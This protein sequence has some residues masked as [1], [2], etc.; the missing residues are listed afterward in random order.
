MSPI[1][2]VVRMQASS[3]DKFEIEIP[4]YPKHLSTCPM[5]ML[6]KGMIESLLIGQITVEGEGSPRSG[7]LIMFPG[8]LR[9]SVRPFEGRG[10]RIS[11]ALNLSLSAVD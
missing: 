10:E 6:G 8:W 7:L 2:K 1:C 9:H 4:T 11:V 3:M 5:V